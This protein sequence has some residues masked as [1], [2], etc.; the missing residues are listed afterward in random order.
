L[1][2]VPILSLRNNDAPSAGS[3]SF[4]QNSFAFGE[5]NRNPVRALN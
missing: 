3:I 4:V 5:G 1:L 2:S